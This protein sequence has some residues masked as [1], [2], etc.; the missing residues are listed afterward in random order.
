M[1]NFA[2]WQKPGGSCWA[3]EEELAEYSELA[4]FGGEI[5]IY[6]ALYD[7]IYCACACSSFID[8]CL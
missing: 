8:A 6:R 3:K 5:V 1:T 4:I 2:T 7:G